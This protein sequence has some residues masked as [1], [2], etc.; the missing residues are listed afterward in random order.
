MIPVRK[1]FQKLLH[2]NKKRTYLSANP[3][4]Q[5]VIKC[6][7]ALFLLCLQ[8]I[9]GILFMVIVQYGSY[10]DASD[11]HNSV[12]PVFGGFFQNS[13]ELYKNYNRK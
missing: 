4:I 2:Q 1:T 7:F 3:K 9:F 5:Q 10:A 11:A 8:T 13:E 12:G 6:K